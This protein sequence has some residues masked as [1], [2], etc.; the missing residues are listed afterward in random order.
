MLR[1][2]VCLG[3]KKVVPKGKTQLFLSCSNLLK[4]PKAPFHDCSARWNKHRV[5]QDHFPEKELIPQPIPTHKPV[6]VKYVKESSNPQLDVDLESPSV[7]LQKKAFEIINNFNSAVNPIEITQ[8]VQQAMNLIN[9]ALI[10]KPHTAQLPHLYYGLGLCYMRLGDWIA[11]EISYKKAIE[12]EQNFVPAYEGMGEAMMMQ[13]KHE[14][15]IAWF[16]KF[17]DTFPEYYSAFG[18]YSNSLNSEEILAQILFKR[19]VCYVRIHDY[20]CA[21]GDLNHVIELNGKYVASAYNWLGKVAC[22]KGKA[23]DAVALFT[24]AI[25]R[26][27]TNYVSYLE[28]S[29]AYLF[30]DQDDLANED[31]RKYQLLKREALLKKL[32]P[33]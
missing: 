19:G 31:R 6:I 29:D 8:K 11:C 14:L 33:T 9:E 28:R 20:P 26:D 10:K 5:I 15:A 2:S 13:G 1:H 25:E 22:Y 12:Y 23:W 4:S 27:P 24:K 17:F 18:E 3:A 16:T 21:S 32:A 30:L 7:H